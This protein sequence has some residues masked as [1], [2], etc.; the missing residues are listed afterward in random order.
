M[1]S[2]TDNGSKTDSDSGGTF[3]RGHMIQRSGSITQI[4]MKDKE[5]LDF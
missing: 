5:E 1:N 4:I 3:L 2:F